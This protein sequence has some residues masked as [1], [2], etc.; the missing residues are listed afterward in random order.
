MRVSCTAGSNQPILKEISPESSL[1]E[2]ILKVKL[3][4]FNHLMQS[5]YSLEKTLMLAK[6]EGKRRGWQRMRWLDTIT[7]LMGMNLSKL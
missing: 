4:H 5:A 7:D 3:Q 2:L 6:I 1:E